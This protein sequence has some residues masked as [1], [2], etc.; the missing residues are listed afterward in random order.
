M[1][2]SDVDLGEVA[3]A[4][5]IFAM[6]LLVFGLGAGCASVDLGPVLIEEP[7]GPESPGNP[8]PYVTKRDRDLVDV[9]CA[10]HGV[11]RAVYLDRLWTRN[12]QWR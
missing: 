6:L 2:L 1:K 7:I 12:P 10:G 5:I 3:L 11:T 9:L 4:I 8:F